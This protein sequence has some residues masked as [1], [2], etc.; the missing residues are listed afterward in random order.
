MVQ[1]KSYLFCGCSLSTGATSTKKICVLFLI[2]GH[3]GRKDTTSKVRGRLS[4]VLAGCLSGEQY[5]PSRCPGLFM[6]HCGAP[7][8]THSPANCRCGEGL[9]KNTANMGLM[10]SSR[11]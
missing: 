3:K 9:A 1:E 8:A 10:S 2:L 4:E 5:G 6:K 11:D 7:A